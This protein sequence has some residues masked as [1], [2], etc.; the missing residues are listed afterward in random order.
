[1]SGVEERVEGFVDNDMLYNISM[2][3]FLR[4]ALGYGFGN[5]SRSSSNGIMDF[6]LD[7]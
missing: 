4:D 5:S 3:N 6:T 7:G 1:M 2:F